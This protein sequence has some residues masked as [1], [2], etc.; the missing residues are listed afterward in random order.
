MTD[1]ALEKLAH[2]CF[3]DLRGTMGRAT[4]DVI[5]RY[6]KEVN[7]INDKRLKRLKQMRANGL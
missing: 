4:Y 1:K 5:L 3:D 6:L 7:K 2:E